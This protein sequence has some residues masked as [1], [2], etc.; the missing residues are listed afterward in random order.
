MSIK[1]IYVALGED[2]Y[3]YCH[4]INP[5]DFESINIAVDGRSKGDRWV[6]IPVEIV[7]RDEHQQLL[8]SDSPW[9]GDHALILRA[10]A[11]LALGEVLGQVG[12]FLPLVCRD[13]RVFLFNPLRALNALD[14]ENS[15]LLRFDD[16]GV[17]LVQKYAFIHDLVSDVDAFKLTNLRVSPTFF[18]K[19]IVD[20]WKA[21]GLTGLKFRRVA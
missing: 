7:R 17:M 10:E 13:A 20:A 12:E 8:R 16:G 3:E 9:L 4:P 21:R 14:E 2:G 15:S 19:R 18:S 5:E 1:E 11:I 6:P